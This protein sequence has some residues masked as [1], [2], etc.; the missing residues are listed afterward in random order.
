MSSP[1]PF[2]FTASYEPA[3]H[4]GDIAG[5]IITLPEQYDNWTITAP[6]HY[7]PRVTKPQAVAELRRFIAEAQRLLALVEAAPDEFDSVTRIAAVPDTSGFDVQPN[8]APLRALLPLEECDPWMWMGRRLEGDRVIEQYKHRYTRGYLN[9]DQDGQAWTW[10]TDRVV[11]PGCAFDC[12]LDRH[13]P[14]HVHKLSTYAAERIDVAT[15]LEWAL[16]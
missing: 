11:D 8:W 14:E 15:A 1:K 3:E 6:S 16:S 12:A 13:D 2:G 4:E 7:D 5:W 9:L 10:R